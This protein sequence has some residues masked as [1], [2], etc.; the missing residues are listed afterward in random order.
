MIGGV[1]NSS[2]NAF[3]A[4]RQ[5]QRGGAAGGPDKADTS[6]TSGKS[7][8]TGQTGAA[9]AD[10]DD[11]QV[12]AKISEL[13]QTDSK[14]HQHEAAH[15]AAG[16]QFAGGATFSYVTGPD[17]NRYAVAGEVSI[18]MSSARDP[19]TTAHNMETVK[20][21]ALAPADP[22]GQDLHVAQQAEQ[23]ATQAQRENAQQAPDTSAPDTSAPDTSAPDTSAPDTSKAGGGKTA[24][25]DKPGTGTSASGG[26]G[27]GLA[28][29]QQA[30]PGG[31]TGG[32][33]G[34]GTGGG[35]GGATGG[36]DGQQPGRV[37]RGLA[38]YGMA[39]GL[40]ATRSAAAP[41]F[42]VNA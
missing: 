19:A 14:V 4:L 39:A 23:A 42:A 37:A 12:Q 32:A 15:Q 31:A 8:A 40:T 24:R 28:G 26:D 20:Q 9:G 5:A 17:G 2:F 21:A 33:T 10:I 29:A 16:G 11:P 34:G 13:R 7:P 41:A 22:S 1:S 38:A 27:L 3:A 25:G 6:A 36:D 30:R 18:S 35:P